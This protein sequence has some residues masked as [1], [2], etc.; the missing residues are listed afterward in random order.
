MD[1]LGSACKNYLGQ[2]VDMCKSL[3]RDYNNYKEGRVQDIQWKDTLNKVACFA[4]KTLAIAA[5]VVATTSFAG[6]ILVGVKAGGMTCF[7]ALKLTTFVVVKLLASHTLMMVG[8]NCYRQ[9]SK[10]GRCVAYLKG[11]YE[12]PRRFVEE[13][14]QVVSSV[15]SGEK[16]EEEDGMFI[17]KGKK[18]LIRPYV[19]GTIL[20]PGL[21]L[22]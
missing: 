9:T 1:P 18:F 17:G 15:F 2:A 11:A 19:Q 6:A 16:E 21:D 4:L 8:E 10:K 12:N 14:G 5:L 13:L 20:S 22:L 3:V 7:S